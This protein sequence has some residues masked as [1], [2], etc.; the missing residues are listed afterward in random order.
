MPSAPGAVFPEP[1]ELFVAQD[2]QILVN[3]IAPRP[4][5]SGHLFIEAVPY[6]SQFKAQLTSIPDETFPPRSSPTSL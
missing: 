1:V 6:M 3:E 2:K 4:H 5:N